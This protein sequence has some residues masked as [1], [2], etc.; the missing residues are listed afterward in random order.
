MPRTLG[1]C[2]GGGM[3]PSYVG[4]RALMKP[5][6]RMLVSL[7]D[8]RGRSIIEDRSQSCALLCLRALRARGTIHSARATQRPGRERRGAEAQGAEPLRPRTDSGAA[9]RCEIA[10]INS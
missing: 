1:I 2:V 6:S 5:T 9:Q 4:F 3:T 7:L 8:A 10:V